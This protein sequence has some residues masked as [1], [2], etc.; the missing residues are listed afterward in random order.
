[1]DYLK[2]SALE[3]MMALKTALINGENINKET[4]SKISITDAFEDLD[5]FRYVIENGYSGYS[6]YPKQKFDTAFMQIKDYLKSL[7]Q[8][9][10]IKTNDWID[11]LCNALEF[12]TDGHMAITTR[13]YSRGFYHPLTTYVA[14]TMVI[15]NMGKYVERVTGKEITLNEKSDELQLLPSLN[16]RGGK[17]YLVGIRSRNEINHIQ[18]CLDGKPVTLSVHKIQSSAITGKLL[19]ETEFSKDTA[20]VMT[21]S[22][23]GN[24][25]Y[26]LERLYEIGKQYRGYK[27]VIWDLSNNG[28]G[29]SD[30]VLAF[31]RGLNSKCYYEIETQIL[32]SSLTHAKYTGEIKELAYKL[33]TDNDA[34]HYEY[35]NAFHGKLYV[36]VNERVASSGEIAVIL[37]KKLEN[38]TI[39]GC[40]TSGRGRFQ[41]IM[42][43]FMP[44]SHIT[45]WCP[46]K[47]SMIEIEE[48]VG[49]SPD[50][51]IDSTSVKSVLIRYLN[52]FNDKE[53]QDN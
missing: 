11:L 48:T 12:I 50:Y 25:P 29:N 30:Y 51:W 41:D 27:N 33:V 15:E 52:T 31:L 7:Q 39:F 53:Q 28:G 37:S 13:I 17:Y 16:E 10:S 26:E 46:H 20:Y 3:N 24:Y 40:N 42:P 2:Y 14:D 47:L 35:E 38:C 6:F 36:I 9:Q 5:Y 43:Y 19:S 8:N 1:M 45:F 34:Q 22:F 49:Y 32:Q 44:K 18:V 21:P 4:P 23:Q